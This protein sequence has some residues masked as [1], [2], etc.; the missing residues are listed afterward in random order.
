MLIYSSM[1]PGFSAGADLRELYEGMPKTDVGG[2]VSGVRD[3]IERIHRVLNAIDTWP[4]P[5]VAAV[6]GVCFGG[7]LDDPYCYADYD[8]SG[9]PDFCAD[10]VPVT[11]ETPEG[12]TQ[13]V[14]L[15][16]TED[17]RLLRGNIASTRARTNLRGYDSDGDGITDSAWVLLAY[18]ESKGLGEEDDEEI[19]K[20]DMGK[21]IWFHT[22]DMRTPELVSQGLMLNQPAV[23]P[24]DFSP[25]GRLVADGSLGYNFMDIEPDPI[26]EDQAGIETTLYQAEIA[27]RFS[28]I[29]QPASAVGPS[30]TV[31]LLMWK[32]GIIRQG[33]PVDVL[34]RRVVLPD[35]FD[36]TTDNPF[37]YANVV[38]EN[39][40]GTS[41]LAF[42]D[43]AN[44]RYVKGLCAAPA[45]NLS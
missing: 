41:G 29:S 8:E 3:F 44:P 26:Y 27:R 14:D 12:P 6:H 32:Q 16:I 37:D 36:P 33:G 43:G 28:L 20:I 42:T 17:G 38:C 45:I 39:P 25:T 21:N 2:R 23:Y 15:C 13:N 34:A 35:D 7:G 18:E 40:D 22:F 30:G 5:T 24:D 11:I 19:D 10:V 4:H 9:T 31:A 1:K